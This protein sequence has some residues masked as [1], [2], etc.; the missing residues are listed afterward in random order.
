MTDLFGQGVVAEVIYKGKSTCFRC[1]VCQVEGGIDAKRSQ[2][3]A[4]FI[5]GVPVIAEILVPFLSIGSRVNMR[6]KAA[7]LALSA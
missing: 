6:S 4:S 3:V 5:G 1:V 2:C 7:Q